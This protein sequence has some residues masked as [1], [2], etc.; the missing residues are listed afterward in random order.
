MIQ[1][2][3]ANHSDYEAKSYQIISNLLHKIGIFFHV[4]IHFNT[5]D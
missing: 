4:S 2:Y 1:A 5:Y 3:L